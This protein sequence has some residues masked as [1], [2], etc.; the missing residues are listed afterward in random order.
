M[1]QATF[2]RKYQPGVTTFNANN[3]SLEA[4]IVEFE[5]GPAVR[6]I[7]KITGVELAHVVTQTFGDDLAAKPSF[8]VRPQRAGWP[9]FETV[10]AA[11]RAIKGSIPS[12]ENRRAGVG[13]MPIAAKPT[14][15]SLDG[16]A[17][18]RRK[19]SPMMAKLL[20]GIAPQPFSTPAF[21]RAAFAR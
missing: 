21:G 12:E 1:D 20:G 2:R 10:P 16:P 9:D 15:T 6:L 14:D 5:G 13:R 18:V 11:L 3:A 17:M 8:L 19:A 7:D 4:S